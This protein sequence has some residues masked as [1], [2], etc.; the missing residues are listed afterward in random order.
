MAIISVTYSIFN[1]AWMHNIYAEFNYDNLIVMIW[2]TLLF[3]T[4]LQINVKSLNISKLITLV[5]KNCMGIYI[6]HVI[7][8][9]I[10]SHLISMSGAVNNIMVIFIVF[11]LSLAISEVIY[12]IPGLRKLVAL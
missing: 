8:L 9:K 3:W 10:I 4:L 7:V 12:R 11:L 6:V 5:S 1:K 2:I